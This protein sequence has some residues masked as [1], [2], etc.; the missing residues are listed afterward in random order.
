MLLF[1]K[2]KTFPEISIN[3]TVQ[4]EEGKFLWLCNA[5]KFLQLPLVMICFVSSWINFLGY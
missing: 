5:F 3:L 4:D 1:L 2:S